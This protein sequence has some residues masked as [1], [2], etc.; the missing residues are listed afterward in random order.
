MVSCEVKA[1]DAGTDIKWYKGQ[2]ATP[3][4]NDNTAYTIS[5]TLA[6][7]AESDGITKISSSGL[8]ILGFD[9][10]DVGSYSCRADYAD[11]ILDD[12]S[13]EQAMAILG[14]FTSQLHKLEML[15]TVDLSALNFFILLTPRS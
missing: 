14:K 12:D 1:S 6:T 7:T 15:D 8:T 5:T 3:L 9:A 13:T 2:S 11:P 10:A 4:E